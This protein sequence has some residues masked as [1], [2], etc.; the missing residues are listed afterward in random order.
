MI[1]GSFDPFHAGLALVVRLACAGS[2]SHSPTKPSSLGRPIDCS[3][4]GTGSSNSP[5]TA[6][7]FRFEAFS[8]EVRKLRGVG[9]MIF[10]RL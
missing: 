3:E 10:I 6:S 1:W 9:P 5:R 8:G 7:E 2:I 4:I